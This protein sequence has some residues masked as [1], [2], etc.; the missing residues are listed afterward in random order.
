[1]G[2]RPVQDFKASVIVLDQGS[3]AFDPITVI[4]IQHSVDDPHFGAMN[5]AAQ[6]AV[7]PAALGLVGHGHFKVGHI[8]ERLFHLLFEVS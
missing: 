3:P 8:V 6:D 7:M 5:V 4:A 1:M 2:R